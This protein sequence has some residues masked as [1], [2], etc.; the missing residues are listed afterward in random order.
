MVGGGSLLNIN[1]ASAAPAAKPAAKATPSPAPAPAPKP[2][3][4][5]VLIAKPTPPPTSPPPPAK[6]AELPSFM[7]WTVTPTP[8]K[9]SPPVEEKRV[10]SGV[11]I[12]LSGFNT[13]AT[14]ALAAATGLA[15]YAEKVPVN[16]PLSI[17]IGALIAVTSKVPGNI[18]EIANLASI[19][20]GSVSLLGAARG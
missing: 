15:A 5:P 8:V 18:G 12:T 16:S 1:S 17:S 4:I 6:V 14:I 13:V 11:K 9:T 19:I 10:E 20:V 3:P 2:A 7:P